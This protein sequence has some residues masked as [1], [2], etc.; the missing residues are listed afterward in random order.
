M[1]NGTRFI[2]FNEPDKP[3]ELEKIEEIITKVKAYCDRKLKSSH[4]IIKKY[5]DI[6]LIEVEDQTWSDPKNERYDITIQYIHDSNFITRQ[7]L[8]MLKGEILDGPE[9]HKR[10]N[11][12][13]S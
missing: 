13:Y 8:L 7:K 11:E 10:F 3:W 2:N 12:F 1:D 6:R 9:F 5:T 4:P